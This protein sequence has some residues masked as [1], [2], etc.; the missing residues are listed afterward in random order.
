MQPKALI[1]AYGNVDRQD[2][3][4]AWHI[5]A[6]LAQRLGGGDLLDPYLDCEIDTPTADLRYMLQL[7]P[8]IAEMMAAYPTVCFLDA[9]ASPQPQ[10]FSLTKLSPDYQ[11]S[12]MTHHMTPE[13]CL[14][15]CQ[16]LYAHVPQAVL[17]SVT[18]YEFGFSRNLSPATQAFIKPA[19]DLVQTWVS[20]QASAA[21]TSQPDQATV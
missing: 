16:A 14:S 9:C 3:G 11:P 15:I 2:D 18:A 5:L 17:L 7:T 6:E 19:A 4:I 20:T 13:T 21:W 1:I 12:P 10:G 8:E